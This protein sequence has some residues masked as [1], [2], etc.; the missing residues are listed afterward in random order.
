MPP[1][2]QEQ[3]AQRG[4]IFIGCRGRG[5]N[6]ME[7]PPE[8]AWIKPLSALTPR[9]EIINHAATLCDFGSGAAGGA[10]LGAHELPR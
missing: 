10:A 1:S 8:G 5:R 7:V 9:L 6:V 4:W 3:L 2:A